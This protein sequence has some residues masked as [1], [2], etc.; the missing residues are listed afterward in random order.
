MNTLPST[1]TRITYHFSRPHL[2][3][4]V[5]G[6]RAAGW[7]FISSP[8]FAA[9]IP[10]LVALWFV[11]LSGCVPARVPDNLDDT[12]GPPVVVSDNWY[13]GTVFSARAPAG[14]RI[15]TSESSAPQ[16]VI[17]AAPDNVAVIRLIDGTVQPADVTISDQ[18][19][20]IAEVT[21]DDGRIITTVLSAPAD[22]WVAFELVYEQ[23]RQSVQASPPSS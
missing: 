15:I 14:W 18:R 9:V 12:P 11:I 6:E 1:G 17:F 4:P 7:G 19:N 21:L 8:R 20:T 3:L 5:N 16:A 22:Q 2:A 23:V 10:F 13:R